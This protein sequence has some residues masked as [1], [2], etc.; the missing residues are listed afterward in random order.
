MRGCKGIFPG[1]LVALI[2]AVVHAE[3]LELDGT[4]KA[5]D[6]TART[7]RVE[8]KTPK[9][10][11]TLELE[12]NKKAGDLSSVKVGDRITFS[13]DPAL[14]VVTKLGGGDLKDPQT[15]R[16]HV[17]LKLELTNTGELSVAITPATGQDGKATGSGISRQ[18]NA[19][20]TWVCSYAFLSPNVL[21]AFDRLK[22]ASFDKA[23]S[24]IVLSGKGNGDLACIGM[25][26]RLST[27]F[28]FECV[29][30]PTGESGSFGVNLIGGDT[31][32][33]M[34]ITVQVADA[35]DDPDACNITV[36]L[37]EMNMATQKWNENNEQ[38][39]NEKVQVAAAW[40]KQLRLPVPNQAHQYRYDLFL[41][42]ANAELKTVRYQG[43]CSP[44]FG[45]ML[46][47]QADT[48]F[49]RKVFPNTI[50]ATSGLQEGDV[51]SAI[52]GKMPKSVAEAMDILAKT[53]FDEPCKI[54][55]ERGDTKKDVVLRVGWDQPASGSVSSPNT[56]GLNNRLRGTTWIN[57]NNA[58][59]EWTNDGRLLHNGKERQW[60][61]L[62]GSSVE[63]TFD[64]TK[65]A[66]LTFDKNLTHFD[67]PIGDG[68]KF[69]G[70]R[71]DR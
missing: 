59:F 40:E 48:V 62:D 15:Q 45:V 57:T 41:I 3:V 12:V 29:G 42:S 33:S 63:V 19:D 11:K 38:L 20:G 32:R 2:A 51:V 61:A 1:L 4:V 39:L 71:V 14:E 67:Q 60:R 24:A 5:V 69:E 9:G 34:H 54:T 46:Q 37:R 65:K 7:I 66:T 28:T 8:R 52:N 21:E 43:A 17:F 47:P 31:E 36:F 35:K 23:A 68:K 13:Y 58:T 6:A 18:R 55:V 16:R 44:V 10:T 22:Y 26:G 56:D 27:P 49:V 70:R 64:P 30:R 50:A 53:T 25:R